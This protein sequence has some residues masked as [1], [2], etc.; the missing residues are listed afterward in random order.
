[1]ERVLDWMKRVFEA[2]YLSGAGIDL[3]AGIFVAYSHLMIAT[4]LTAAALPVFWYLFRKEIL[5]LFEKDEAIL[6]S[7][8]KQT[9]EEDEADEK[10]EFKKLLVEYEKSMKAK[11]STTA[12]KKMKG[13]VIIFDRQFYF[14]SDISTIRCLQH[15]IHN[16]TAVA[17]SLQVCGEG[18]G[19]E[20]DEKEVRCYDEH[21][22]MRSGEI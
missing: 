13:K 10:A 18:T 20:G 8:A 3:G 14:F 15:S 16:Y 9:A 1:M 2:V 21:L 7:M 5:T 6:S 19:D 22:M 12:M 17:C 11:A 4:T